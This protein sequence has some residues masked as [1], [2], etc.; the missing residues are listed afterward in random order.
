MSSEIACRI[1]DVRQDSPSSFRAK[2]LCEFESE[3][4]L[5]LHQ[6]ELNKSSRFPPKLCFG[7]KEML[8][9]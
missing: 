1:R 5:G 4:H 9:F 7:A 8:L 6:P 2:M 3:A